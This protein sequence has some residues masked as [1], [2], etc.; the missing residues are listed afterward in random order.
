MTVGELIAALAS[1]A[2]NEETDL[3]RMQVSSIDINGEDDI[4]LSFI[5]GNTPDIAIDSCGNILLE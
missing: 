4:H 5:D 3:M 1:C 2:S